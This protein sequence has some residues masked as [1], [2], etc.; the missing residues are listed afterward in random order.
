MTTMA[1][2]VDGT[3]SRPSTSQRTRANQR[4]SSLRALEYVESDGFAAGTVAGMTVFPFQRRNA[5]CI[6]MASLQNLG[7]IRMR[8]A[9][10]RHVGI[11]VGVLAAVAIFSAPPL[12][13]QSKNPITAAREALKKAKEQQQHEKEKAQHRRRRRQPRRLRLRPPLPRPLHR[14]VT[15]VVRRRSRRSRLLPVSSTSSASNSA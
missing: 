12:G 3:R 8:A 5:I 14:A 13:A 11:V 9:I 10:L 7:G 2:P 15:A 4:D 6:L 1:G